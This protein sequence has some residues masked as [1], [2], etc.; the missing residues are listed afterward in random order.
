MDHSESLRSDQIRSD[1]I[2]SDQIRSDPI[3]GFADPW[4][5][6]IDVYRNGRQEFHFLNTYVF[7]YFCFFFSS[8][9]F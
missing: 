8:I 2:R 1:Q 7:F 3:H 4:G 5:P 9:S 6:S